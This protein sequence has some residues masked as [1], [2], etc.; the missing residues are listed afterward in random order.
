MTSTQRNHLCQVVGVKTLESILRESF[1]DENLS[2]IDCNAVNFLPVGENFGSELIKLDVEISRGRTE[3]TEE[4]N[5]LAKMMCTSGDSI[6]CWKDAFKKEVFVYT[7]LLPAYQE[8]ETEMGI[9]KNFSIN[10]V[11][12][13]YGHCYSLSDDSDEVGN[14]SLFLMENMKMRDYYV[15]NMKTGMILQI[16][17]C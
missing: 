5:M 16:N 14:D 9:E 12:K 3:Q 15:L 2:V 17:H 7:K 4:L 6:V 10:L 8:L 11:P 1:K 13:Y